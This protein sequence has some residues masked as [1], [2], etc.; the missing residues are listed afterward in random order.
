MTTKGAQSSGTD[1]QSMFGG[2]KSGE[3]MLR[4][5]SRALKY[6]LPNQTIP[7]APATIRTAPKTSETLPQKRRQL[8]SR[9]SNSDSRGWLSDSGAR[10]TYCS[11]WSP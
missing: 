5:C 2:A 6:R 11:M 1:P 7:D 4:P 10:L 9:R 8:R 3:Q